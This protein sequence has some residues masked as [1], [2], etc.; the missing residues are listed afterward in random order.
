MPKGIY[1]RTKEARKNMSNSHKGM[2]PWNTGGHHSKESN[3]KN[4]EAHLGKKHTEET[5]NR[6]SEIHKKLKSGLKFQRWWLGRKRPPFTEEHK[7][8]LSESH[9]KYP[10]DRKHKLN[11]IRGSE[12]YRLWRTAVFERDNYTCIWCGQRGGYLEADHIKPFSQYPE[13]RFAID[14]GRTLCKECHRTTDTYMGRCR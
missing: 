9:I 5:K 8:K 2:K 7:K 11:R 4:R 1:I 14:N 10:E 6:M 12:E 3:D 13:L